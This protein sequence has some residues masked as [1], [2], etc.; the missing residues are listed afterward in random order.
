[1]APTTVLKLQ[2]P[3]LKSSPSS[4]NSLGERLEYKLISFEKLPVIFV[5]QQRQVLQVQLGENGF[6]NKAHYINTGRSEG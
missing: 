5:H 2:E 4:Y 1:M 3:L 6:I